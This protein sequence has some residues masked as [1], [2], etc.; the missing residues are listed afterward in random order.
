M[1]VFFN[2]SLLKQKRVPYISS[3]PSNTNELTVIP[4][5]F[6]FPSPSTAY[7]TAYEFKVLNKIIPSTVE[8]QMTRKIIPKGTNIRHI[9]G[10]NKKSNSFS[11]LIDVHASIKL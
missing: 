6:N 5:D 3:S 11:W 8:R 9:F 10:R 7:K 2:W 4:R 1:V